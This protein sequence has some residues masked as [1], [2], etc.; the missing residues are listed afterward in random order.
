MSIANANRHAELSRRLIEQPITSCTL[1][2]T[3]VQASDKAS[4][5]VAQAVMAIAEDR[6]RRH[7]SLNLRRD[8]IN[9]MAFE[10]YL[11]QLRYLQ[12]IADQLHEN[13]YEDQL[14]VSLVVP[15]VDDVNRL[16]EN[17]WELREGGPNPN[18]SAAPEQQRTIGRLPIPEEV[19]R[20]DETVDIPPPMPPCN[21]PTT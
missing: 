6:N 2:A 8:F 13:F 11:P 7:G 5:A 21:Q 1:W 18:Y 19:A 9:V 3:G 4:G 16:M 20:A 10:F 12:A 14:D 15:L 17:L